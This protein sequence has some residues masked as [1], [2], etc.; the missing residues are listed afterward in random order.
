MMV[1]EGPVRKRRIDGTPVLNID[2]VKGAEDPRH[3][4]SLVRERQV[5]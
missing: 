3:L 1:I 2:E 5:K 4:L